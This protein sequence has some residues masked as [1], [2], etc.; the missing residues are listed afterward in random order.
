MTLMS[1]P[2]LPLLIA[3]LLLPFVINPW[4]LIVL[5]GAPILSLVLIWT[6]P[7]GGDGDY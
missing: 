7:D 1:S 3:A 4:R 5:L 6:W 2:S